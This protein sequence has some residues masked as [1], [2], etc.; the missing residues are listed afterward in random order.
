MNETHEIRVDGGSAWCETC[1]WSAGTDEP[2]TAFDLAYL[3]FC[4]PDPQRDAKGAPQT[5][6]T[7]CDFCPWPDR[8][9]VSGRPGGDQGVRQWPR[10]ARWYWDIR[11]HHRDWV[12]ACAEHERLGPSGNRH[13][14]KLQLHES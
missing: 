13:A 9:W 12:L 2:F 4:D 11:D 14:Y 8:I 1:D 7:V 10:P 5:A 6:L 3:H